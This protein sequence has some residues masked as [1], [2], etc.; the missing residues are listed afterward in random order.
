MTYRYLQL[1]HRHFTPFVDDEDDFNQCVK[2]ARTA[3]DYDLHYP[4]AVYDRH[5]QLLFVDHAC[6]KKQSAEE[7]MDY[8]SKK[9]NLSLSIESIIPINWFDGDLLDEE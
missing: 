8:I 5:T 6:E 7:W 1:N 2:D 9:Y 3:I 4:K